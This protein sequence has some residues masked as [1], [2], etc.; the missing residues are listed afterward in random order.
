[1]DYPCWATLKDLNIKRME[2]DI[3]IRKGV[4]TIQ[5]VCGL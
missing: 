3:P 5:F 2:R 4:E 1:M